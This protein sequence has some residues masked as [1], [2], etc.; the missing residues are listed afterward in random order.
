M[1]RAL[2]A[3]LFVLA[4]IASFILAFAAVRVPR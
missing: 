4:F 3:Y 1:T 2:L